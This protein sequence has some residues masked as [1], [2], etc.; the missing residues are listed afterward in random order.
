M[1]QAS[2]LLIAAI[3]F[4]AFAAAWANRTA[5]SSDVV[6]DVQDRVVLSAPIQLL[7]AG[8][9]RFLAADFEA[10]RIA[11]TGDSG[12]QAGVD[13][14]AFRIRAHRVVAQLNACHEDNY[15]VGNALLS[16]G[17]APKDGS[18]LLRRAMD[19]RTWDE[20]PAFFYGVNQF[21]FHRNASEAVRALEFAAQRSAANAAAIRKLA[22]MIAADELHDERLALE[23][24]RR[25]RNAST[26][27]KLRQML[28]RRVARLSGLIT[29]RDA[30]RRYEARSGKTLTDP[31]A[32]IASG[33][34]SALP[35]DPMGIGY[36]FHDG[37]FRLKQLRIAGMEGPK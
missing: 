24:L 31:A 30:Q 2:A 17:G 10:I 11:A 37:S 14:A 28:D 13:D 1:R 36:E 20:F 7:M 4:A 6:A 23:Y 27:A 32:L 5:S 35:A 15:Y 8:G 22:I 33:E 3:G 19:C 12:P 29:L 34:L 26:D 21:F 25:E 16:W 9:D 18:D